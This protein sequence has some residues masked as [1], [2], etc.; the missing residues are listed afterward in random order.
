MLFVH[1]LPGVI[2]V[3]LCSRPSIS[4]FLSFL[5]FTPQKWKDRFFVLRAN[6]ILECHKSRKAAAASSKAPRKVIDLRSCIT[7]EV[8]LEYR[9]LQHILSL[10]TFKKTFFFAAHSD[11]LM[12][13]WGDNIEKVKNAS[14]GKCS[15]HATSDT[16]LAHPLP[17]LFS[18]MNYV[19]RGDQPTH[20]AVHSLA[21]IA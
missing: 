19:T 12:L 21:S 2:G 7:L 11:A 17:L 16:T 1:G 5:P 20:F 4:H 8:G 3:H 6:K 10:G 18:D 9:E 14:D 15:Q 13:Q